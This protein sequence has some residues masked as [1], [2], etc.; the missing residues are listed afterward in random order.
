MGCGRW[1]ALDE[2]VLLDVGRIQQVGAKHGSAE[3][4]ENEAD[5]QHDRNGH[6]RTTSRV[7][8]SCFWSKTPLLIVIVSHGGR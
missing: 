1:L 4:G 3:D 5:G 8:M 2:R 7:S 6:S